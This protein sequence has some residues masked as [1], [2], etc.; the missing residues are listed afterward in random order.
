[1]EEMKVEVAG[2]FILSV[3]IS[4]SEFWVNVLKS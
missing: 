4:F 2:I 1:M 3:N